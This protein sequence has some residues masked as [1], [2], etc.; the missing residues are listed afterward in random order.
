MTTSLTTCG[1][2]G[3]IVMAQICAMQELETP[4]QTC[5]VIHQAVSLI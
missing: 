5:A 4:N 3:A 2:A 1:E